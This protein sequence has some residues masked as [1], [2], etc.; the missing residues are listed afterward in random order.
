LRGLSIICIPIEGNV[1]I[2]CLNIVA[3]FGAFF[4]GEMPFLRVSIEPLTTTDS[5]AI[6]RVSDMLGR[7]KAIIFA[8]LVFCVGAVLMTISQ[9]FILL[10]VGRIITGG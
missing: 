10:L 5:N 4:A 8:C 6:G 1:I 7:K 9:E 3:A 2:G